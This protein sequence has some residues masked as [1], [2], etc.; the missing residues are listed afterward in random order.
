MVRYIRD[1]EHYSEVIA[2]MAKAQRSLWIATADLK[3]LYVKTAAKD[4][5]PF[6]EVLSRLVQR[7]VEVRLL[8]AK[9]PGQSFREDFDR[10]PALWGGMERHLCPPRACQDSG[11]RQ[12]VGIYR[13]GEYDRCGYGDEIGAEPQF[14]G[15]YSDRRARTNRRRYGALRR[16]LLRFILFPLWQKSLLPRP[17]QRK[18]LMFSFYYCKMISSVNSQPN[19]P[20]RMAR[21]ISAE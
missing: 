6:L 5:I 17:H 2:R 15:G 14:R 13:F 21:A 12:R 16:H 1:T 11:D 10:Y 9:E 7:G 18:G 4:P 19:N 8:H 3:D 20:N